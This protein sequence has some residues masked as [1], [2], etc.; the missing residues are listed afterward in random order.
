[1]HG[2]KA[3]PDSVFILRRQQKRHMVRHQHPRPDLDIRRTGMLGQEI[4]IKR[5]IL[6]AEEGLL[7]AIASLRH[8]MRQPGKNGASEQSMSA[9][10]KERR[11]E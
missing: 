3:A 8:M 4:P 9:K 1:M 6:I 10:L 7:A 11:S 2:G 5:V